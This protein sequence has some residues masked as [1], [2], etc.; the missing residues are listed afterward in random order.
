M[1]TKR[2][3]FIIIY[4][5]TLYN[6]LISWRIL[7]KIKYFKF[8]IRIIF[9]KITHLLQFSFSQTRST[10]TEKWRLINYYLG[11]C[12]KINPLLNDNNKGFR[13][14]YNKT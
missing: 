13:S 14:R 6:F 11:T 8:S 3:L 9:T 2:N 10:T 5:C 12:Y 7:K 4:K 1:R